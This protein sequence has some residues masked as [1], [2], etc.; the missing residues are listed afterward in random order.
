MFRHRTIAIALIASTIGCAAIL[1]LDDVAY[2]PADAGRGDATA[3]APG[4]TADAPADAPADAVAVDAP[5]GPFCPQPTATDCLDFDQGS[6]LPAGWG[7]TV[8]GDGGVY[9]EA[10]VATSPPNALFSFLNGATISLHSARIT[11]SLGSGGE[12]RVAFDFMLVEG[13]TGSGRNATIAQISVIDGTTTHHAKLLVDESL[14]LQLQ[15]IHRGGEA[16][17]SSPIIGSLGAITPG[18]WYRL[19]LAIRAQIGRAHV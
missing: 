4:A 12:G 1:G 10:G 16:G 13:A 14:N 3:D 19:E 9:V 6:T 18:V 15:E 7:P 17:A 11:R 5:R 2:T 8:V